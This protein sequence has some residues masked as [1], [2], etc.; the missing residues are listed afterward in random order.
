MIP[1]AQN[2][3]LN[4]RYIAFFRAYLDTISKALE[5]TFFFKHC[6]RQAR[7]TCANLQALLELLSRQ[8]MHGAVQCN[9]YD[10]T[11]CLIVMSAHNA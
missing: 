8:K 2:N 9:I 11:I 10:I 4:N 5:A 7:K 6:G 3:P 1:A